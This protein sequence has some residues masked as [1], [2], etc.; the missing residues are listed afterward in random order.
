MNKDKLERLLQQYFNNTITDT[1]CI[2]LLDYLRNNDPDEIA[3]TIDERLLTLEEGPEF[4]RFQAKKVLERIKSDSRFMRRGVEPEDAK[5]VNKWYRSW[6]R[7]AAILIFFST[8][9]FY[10]LFNRYHK[11]ANQNDLA[12]TKSS[13]I[14][15]G[16]TKA[17][18]TLANGKVIL[19]DSAAD[20]MLTKSGRTVV[21]K[22][23]NEGLVYNTLAD[24]H[25]TATNTD[26]VY[27][28]LTTPRGGEYKVKLPDGTNV[29]LNSS[30][31]LSYPVEFAGNE[32]HVKL[33]GEAYFEVAKNKDK[34]FYVCVNNV[35]VKVLGTHFNIAA[36]TD[37]A[38][39][40]TTLLEGSV[41][42]TKNSQQ[43]LLKPGQQAVVKNNADVIN[44]SDAS[45]NQV[46]AWKNGYFVFND[47]NINTIMKKLSRW[48]DV[49]VEYQGSFENQRFGGTFYR[50]KGITELLNN[51]EKIGKVHFKITGRRIIV[52][53]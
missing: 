53:Q 8:V 5:P 50:S 15:P 38:E 43:R 37:D 32:R 23:H 35:C 10:F 47:D 41:L 44:V 12:G 17:T 11:I 52:M 33:T 45:I 22:A 14:L 26:T 34:P 27:N 13:Q 9:G 1:D 25:Q 40:T 3:K 51:L 6:I 36:Y 19:L 29:W 48:Y 20:G 7:V 16:S 28:T 21:N 39:L 24:N 18:L 46:M 2:E 31:S 42:I 4:N 30:S 49:D